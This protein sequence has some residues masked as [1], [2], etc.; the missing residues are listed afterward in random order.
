MMRIKLSI[1]IGIALLFTF[2]C[3]RVDDKE[4][5]II[6]DSLKIGDVYFAQKH[7]LDPKSSTFKLISDLDCLIKVQLN[8]KRN[9]RAPD[10]KAILKLKGEEKHIKL[11]GPR[12]LPSA[13]KGI[14]E[15]RPHSYVDSFTA[16]IPAKWVK[17]E[18]TIELELSTLSGNAK[19]VRVLDKKRF[20]DLNI[21]APNVMKMTMYD[22]HYFGKEIGN[23]YPKG[24]HDELSAKLA[25]SKI[26]LQ[27]IRKIS[28]NELTNL[29]RGEKPAAKC[30]SPEEYLA[31]TGLS[32]D[33]EQ[34]L[35]LQW[36][37]A[38]KSANGCNGHLRGAYHSFINIYGVHSGGQARGFF[39]VGSGNR[40]GVLI[41]E[42]GHTFGLPDGWRKHTKYP[43]RGH[44]YGIKTKSAEHPHAGP[45]WAF[46]LNKRAFIPPVVQPRSEERGILGH[47][48]G[49]PMAGGG[50]GDQEKGY[51]YKHFSDF[52][53]YRMMNYME[54][55][56][57]VWNDKLKAYAKWNPETKEYTSIL[58]LNKQQLPIKRDVQVWSILFSVSAAT[59][60]VTII[61]PPIGPYKGNL[62]EVYDPTQE[63]SRNKASA[64][65]LTD[66]K[67]NI[68]VRVTQKNAVTT[69]IVSAFVSKKDDPLSRNSLKT[70]ALNVSAENGE[71]NKIELF[72]VENLISEGL[73]DKTKP[74]CVWE[75]PQ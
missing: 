62:L 18:L 41:H 16:F 17:P 53:V 2:G 43:Y 29:P 47:W 46:D 54:K 69:S 39:G 61:Y 35:A 27:R 13:Y 67:C 20:D 68:V 30:S 52:S 37:G 24:W 75:K 70:K 44:M 12:Y 64:Y 9:V 73:N 19:M 72:K 42:L 57:T 7:V 50:W 25:V 1:I 32:F 31:K 49:D 28:F 6:Y 3:R 58:E 5:K 63:E 15:L 11:I 34:A 65:G 38:L 4:L 40:P 23:D 59:P 48:K 74:I 36:N 55:H 56:A 22:I 21:G 8:S 71:V 33:G 45:V 14:P 10:L 66:E 60:D 51:I 26:D